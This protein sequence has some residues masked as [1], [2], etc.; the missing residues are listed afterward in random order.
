[1]SDEVERAASEAFQ[2]SNVYEGDTAE[3]HLEGFRRG[4][5]W[6]RANPETQEVAEEEEVQHNETDLRA[7]SKAIHDR[8]LSNGYWHGLPIGSIGIGQN[9]IVVYCRQETTDKQKVECAV[10]AKG[11][12]V[13]FLTVGE[14]KML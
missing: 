2:A 12:P 14:M 6:G 11:I 10:L 5:E 9:K 4:V 7:A 8:F 3:W 13:E 1:M